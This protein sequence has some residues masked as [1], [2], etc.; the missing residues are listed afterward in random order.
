MRQGSILE[1]EGITGELNRTMNEKSAKRPDSK[2]YEMIDEPKEPKKP[3]AKP[4]RHL[5]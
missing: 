3:I 1:Y 2:R 4:K 5:K